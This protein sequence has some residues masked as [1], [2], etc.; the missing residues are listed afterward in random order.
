MRNP[1]RIL[2]SVHVL[3]HLF[4]T[5]YEDENEMDEAEPEPFQ[6]SQLSKRKRVKSNDNITSNAGD[7][8]KGRKE[9]KRKKQAIHI[10]AVINDIDN[11]ATT[12]RGKDGNELE[13]NKLQEEKQREAVQPREES[14]RK[15]ERIREEKV[16]SS[17][18]PREENE[19]EVARLG[20]EGDREADRGSEM[21]EQE[22]VGLRVEEQPEEEMERVTEK[23]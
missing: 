3:G 1:L 16:Q 6:P 21:K 10:S 22:A 11:E 17:A 2:K 5:E 19:Q 18:R 12:Q 7:A 14:E 23:V 9:T 20:A 15:V 8:K 13:S 4:E